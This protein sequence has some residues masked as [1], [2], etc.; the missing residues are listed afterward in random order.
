MAMILSGI[1]VF[2]KNAAKTRPAANH[3]ARTITVPPRFEVDAETAS[4]ERLHGGRYF[5]GRGATRARA[6]RAQSIAS[7]ERHPPPFGRNTSDLGICS[8]GPE[9][10]GLILA[11]FTGERRIQ[12]IFLPPSF[13]P[14]EERG[15]QAHRRLQ[16]VR[17]TEGT[18]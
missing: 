7:I 1:I 9:R 8:R 2:M 3:A 11:E 10:R 12:E 17:A 15:V 18:S 14:R 6:S 16:L 5:A 13:P 4:S